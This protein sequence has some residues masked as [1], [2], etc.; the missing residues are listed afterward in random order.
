MDPVDPASQ[1]GQEIHE[2]TIMLEDSQLA[3]VGE[4]GS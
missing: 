1:E 3:Q 2:D 4:S